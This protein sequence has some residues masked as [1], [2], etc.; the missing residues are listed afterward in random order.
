MA[1]ERQRPVE[2]DKIKRRSNFDAVES[3]FT[4][5]Q[6]L[7]REAGNDLPAS[8]PPEA[9]GLLNLKRIDKTSGFDSVNFSSSLP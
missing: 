2:Q 9:N 4:E 8:A 1:V 7:F 6:M 5:E 3:N